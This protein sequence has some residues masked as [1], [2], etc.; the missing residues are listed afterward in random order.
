MKKIIVILLCSFCINVQAQTS[1]TLDVIMLLKSAKEKNFSDMKGE[2][3]DRSGSLIYYEVL[4]SNLGGD[5]ETIIK[6]SVENTNYYYCK[7]TYA[8]LSNT[9][10]VQANK[11]I[12]DVLGV[13]NLK[14]KAGEYEGKDFDSQDNK[15]SITQVWD[16]VTKKTVMAIVSDKENTYTSIIIYAN[17]YWKK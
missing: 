15:T 13:L 11:S 5:I 4:M 6:D 17:D 3:L 14:I 1:K 9:A 12:Q 10:L 7:F 16:K 2:V 8:K